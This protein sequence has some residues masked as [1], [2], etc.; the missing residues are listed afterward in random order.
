MNKKMLC[1]AIATIC[2]ASGTA[3]ADTLATRNNSQ[4]NVND[5]WGYYLDVYTIQDSNYYKLRDIICIMNGWNV[6]LGLEYNQAANRIDITSGGV[7]EILGT[8]LYANSSKSTATAKQ[9]S[10]QLYVDGNRVTCSA[11]EIN[12][13]TYFKLRDLADPIGFDVQYNSATGQ[14]AI[15]PHNNGF[16]LLDFMNETYGMDLKPTDAPKNTTPQF[17][18][19]TKGLD[20]KTA[21]N[22]A[23]LNP[24]KTKLDDLN[25]RIEQFMA[26]HFTPDMD[27]YTK[28]KV[29]YDYI[30]KNMTYATPDIAFDDSPE[31]DAGYMFLTNQGV[32]DHY[33]A[34]FA[35]IMRYVGLDMHVVNGYTHAASGGMTGHTWTTARING[36]D[37]VFDPQIDQN[38]GGKN[39]PTY[40]RFGKP[41]SE[42]PGK[43]EPQAYNDFE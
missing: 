20:I 43:Y 3:K 40:Y 16:K 6:T 13:S 35:A 1:A 27:T 39:N 24:Q 4:L 28:A 12:G 30:I 26:E 7:Y 33:S 10:I 23:T 2:I 32:C 25:Q 41:Y 15:Y 34:F 36:L 17:D 38:I 37:Y 31:N 29:T 22:Q 8:E 42:L 14:V 18:T 21:L 9:S 11:Y 5:E 19:T